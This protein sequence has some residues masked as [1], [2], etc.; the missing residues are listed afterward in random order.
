M[1][2]EVGAALLNSAQ[3]GHDTDAAFFVTSFW[4]DI[5]SDDNYSQASEMAEDIC[6]FLLWQRL[7]LH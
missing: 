2:D 7:S 1:I 6:L 4:V 3:L 5:S